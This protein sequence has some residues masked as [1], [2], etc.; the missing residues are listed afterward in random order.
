MTLKQQFDT[1]ISKN[2]LKKF[3]IKNTMAAPRIN[4]VVINTG[5]GDIMKD[6]GKIEQAKKDMSNIT[7]QMPSVRQAKVSVASFGIRAGNPVGLSA[8]LR[9]ERMYSFL[10]KLFNIVLPRL[11]DFRGVSPDSFDKFGNYTLGIAEHTVFPEVDIA[12]STPRGM[13]ITIVTSTNS[14]EEAHELLK[15]LGMPFQKEEDNG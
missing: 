3:D 1:E 9:G 11:R 14:K 6:K 10:N 15:S 8:T 4:K 13:E 2:L 5:I 7:G 12:Q